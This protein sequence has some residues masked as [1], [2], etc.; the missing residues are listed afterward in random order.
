MYSH[1]RVIRDV[2]KK[3]IK[4]SI[5]V[6]MET[7]EEH[8]E[9]SFDLGDNVDIVSIIGEIKQVRMKHSNYFPLI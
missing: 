6:N 3:E 9:I 5:A 1:Y 8:A 2:L 7:L 4:S